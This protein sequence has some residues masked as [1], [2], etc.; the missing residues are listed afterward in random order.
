MAS[1]NPAK[2]SVVCWAMLLLW[3]Y[4]SIVSNVP[5]EPASNA[6]ELGDQLP[7]GSN[8]ASYDQ[9]YI[10]GWPFGYFEIASQG[11]NP[12][13]RTYKPR[14]AI[15]NLV[16]IAATLFA[17]V[18]AVQNWIPRFSIRTMMAGVAITACILIVGQLVFSTDSFYLQFG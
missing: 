12:P 18:Y 13:V 14:Y 2:W 16:V 6:I 17:L 5:I 9:T 11:S 15:I 10:A 4:A 8:Y 3:L 1:L 7:D